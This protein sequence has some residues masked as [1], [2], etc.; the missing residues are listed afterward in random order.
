VAS[1]NEERMF[2]GAVA[3][4][5]FNGVNDK[6]A[7]VFV[8]PDKMG[9]AIGKGGSRIKFAQE[10]LGLRIQLD[11][12]ETRIESRL[13]KSEKGNWV[14]QTRTLITN[15]SHEFTLVD[16]HNSVRGQYDFDLRGPAPKIPETPVQGLLYFPGTNA[17]EKLFQGI[18]IQG[19]KEW[20]S[21]EDIKAAAEFLNR[22]GVFPWESSVEMIA[23]FNASQEELVSQAELPK[24][25]RIEIDQIGDVWGVLENG[26]K[27]KAISATVRKPDFKDGAISVSYKFG[28]EVHV[29]SRNPF[30][31]RSIEL[32]EEPYAVLLERYVNAPKRAAEEEARRI[33]M[34]NQLTLA[35]QKRVSEGDLQIPVFGYFQRKDGWTGKVLQNQ[36]H[37][38][39]VHI[40]M[41]DG[42][43]EKME[44]RLICS[45]EFNPDIEVG[46][47]SLVYNDQK[48]GF[49]HERDWR[50]NRLKF[51]IQVG[52]SLHKLSIDEK[53]LFGKYLKSKSEEGMY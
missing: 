41:T 38:A 35:Q 44:F 47:A 12:A 51:V 13:V 53:S 27:T 8:I 24:V 39:N 21:S 9:I 4:I 52:G 17:S 40:W 2:D 19:I 34:Q 16:W 30:T 46:E 37:Y 3:A 15:T 7:K 49:I 26:G 6:L 32:R 22:P 45:A 42:E 23:E 48:R 18:N 5:E 36:G 14:V 28:E 20:L 43:L 10:T 29:S 11:K 50:A 33:Q 1:A 25:V 31:S